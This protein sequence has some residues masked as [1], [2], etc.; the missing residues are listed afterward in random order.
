LSIKG[1]YQRSFRIGRHSRI[2]ST[3]RAG[4]LVLRPIVELGSPRRL[5]AGHLPGVL[6]PSVVFRGKVISLVQVSVADAGIKHLHQDIVRTQITPLERKGD[7]GVSD[8]C[9]A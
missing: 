7:N 6:E 5:V 9:A 1:P 2:R 3:S 4:N 8:D